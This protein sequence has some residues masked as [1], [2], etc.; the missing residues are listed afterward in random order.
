MIIIASALLL[1]VAI[2][3]IA[4]SASRSMERA[5]TG[6][7]RRQGLVLAKVAANGIESYVHTITTALHALATDS[8]MLRMS[9]DAVR[10]QLK[11]KAQELEHSGVRDVGVIDAKGVLRFSGMDRRMEGAD[12]SARRYFQEGKGAASSDSQVIQF[13]DMEGVEPPGGLLVG[14]PMFRP[15]PDGEALEF[16]GI[17][18]CV[19]D[20]TFLADGFI[21]PV[22]QTPRGRTFFLDGDGIVLSAADRSLIGRDVLTGCDDLDAFR[23]VVQRMKNGEAGTAEY[24]HYGHDDETGEYAA[25]L[26][27]MLIAFAPVR[28]G[29][30]PWSIGVWA[31]TADAMGDIRASR[32]L[33]YVVV[34]LSVLIVLAGAAGAVTVCARLRGMLKREVDIK[35]AELRQKQVEIDA[36]HRE[37]ADATDKVSELFETAGREQ[38]LGNYFE[39]PNL[40]TC[41]KVR[42]CSNS[43]CPCHGQEGVRCWQVEGTYCDKERATPFVEKVLTCGS[44]EVYRQSCPDRLTELAEGFNNVMY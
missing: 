18:M 5:A 31:P 37:L 38:V 28:V 11:L 42:D 32:R 8:D 39:N 36:S 29:G 33:Q 41:W 30:R 9:E 34:G 2:L 15:L 14:V 24:L 12:F 17:V 6:E 20:F 4:S 10:Y 3:L 1:V 16:V 13:I 44:C 21:Q 25:D 26:E 23:D 43:W 35:T 19:V 40:A 7:F 27:E 22:R